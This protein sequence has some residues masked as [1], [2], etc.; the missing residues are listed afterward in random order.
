MGL[1]CPTPP[2]EK[3]ELGMDAV[4]WW[5][6]LCHLVLITLRSEKGI[7]LVFYDDTFNTIDRSHIHKWFWKIIPFPCAWVLLQW[8]LCQMAALDYFMLCEARMAW[9]LLS[10]FHWEQYCTIKMKHNIIPDLLE[11]IEGSLFWKHNC[12][13]FSILILPWN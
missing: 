6:Q 8:A 7:H 5:S 10:S 4:L 1:V 3:G 12:I 9:I 2:E 13:S 11:M